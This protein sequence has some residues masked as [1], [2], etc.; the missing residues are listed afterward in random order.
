MVPNP[1]RI[2]ITFAYFSYMQ[3]GN[4]LGTFTYGAWSESHDILGVCD[5][6]ETLYFIKGNGEEIT[7]SSRAHLKVSSP[8]IGL[9]PQDDSDAR[10]SCL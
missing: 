2:A 4:G 8:I 9:I 5:D 1:Y 10:G 6:S 3:S 7:R